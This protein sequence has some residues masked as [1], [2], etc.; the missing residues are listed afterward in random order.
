MAPD[1]PPGYDPVRPG[2]I[3]RDIW[4][5]VSVQGGSGHGMKCGLRHLVFG[6]RQQV[7]LDYS[8]GQ[9]TTSM[10]GEVKEEMPN[11]VISADG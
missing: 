2:M 6:L 9:N 5:R 8:I 11:D 4:K 10:E 3:S 7:I 1:G